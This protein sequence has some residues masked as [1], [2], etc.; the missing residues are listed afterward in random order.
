MLDIE[1]TGDHNKVPKLVFVDYQNIPVFKTSH[2][3]PIGTAA[4]N[5]W[6]KQNHGK[7]SL[8]MEYY[9]EMRE[10]EKHIAKVRKALL[11]ELKGDFD[12]YLID[13]R[14]EMFL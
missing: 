1:R 4:F 6:S 8:K 2:E 13:E 5:S 14:P 3:S 7:N 9:L 11:I 12:K 10:Q